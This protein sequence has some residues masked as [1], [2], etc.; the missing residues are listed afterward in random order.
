MAHAP[1]AIMQKGTRACPIQM[2]SPPSSEMAPVHRAGTQ[3]AAT[4]CRTEKYKLTQLNIP[5]ESGSCLVL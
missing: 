3:K 4:A 1:L 2:P 5:S